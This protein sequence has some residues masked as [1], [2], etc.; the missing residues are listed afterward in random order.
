MA[1]NAA[2][3]KGLDRH[4]GL[5][6]RCSNGLW[7]GYPVGWSEVPPEVRSLLVQKGRVTHREVKRYWD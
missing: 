7:H 5:E 2:R 3:N 6:Q 4:S 1:S